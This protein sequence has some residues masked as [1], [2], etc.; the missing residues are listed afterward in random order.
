MRLFILFLSLFVASSLYGQNSECYYMYDFED[1]SNNKTTG[2]DEVMH[3]FY[4]VFNYPPR[5]RE[6]GLEAKVK[7]Y[8][9]YHSEDDIEF[10]AS[11]KLADCHT[12]LNRYFD[13]F[14]KKLFLSS[15]ESY[16]VE[17]YLNF[18]LEP[19]EEH[20]EVSNTIYIQAYK[21][22]IKY[23]NKSAQ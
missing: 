9:I 5:C 19:F 20:E 22:R 14:D 6:S 18:D 1:F 11:G 10:I 21:P 16:M 23:N 3:E 13:N 17:F 7:C 15:S 12:D 8:L 4:T 2:Y